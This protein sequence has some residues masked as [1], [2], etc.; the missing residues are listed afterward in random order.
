MSKNK[1]DRNQVRTLSPKL[2]VST[3]LLYHCIVLITQWYL[4]VLVYIQGVWLA[5]EFVLSKII[6]IEELH[7]NDHKEP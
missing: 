1:L 2:N 4:N 5:R 7:S 3:T 6:K